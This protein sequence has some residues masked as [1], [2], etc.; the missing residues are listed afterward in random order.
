MSTYYVATTGSNSNNGSI[1]SPFL[2]I[3]KGVSV[4][5]A[6]DTLYIRGGTYL[7]S[8]NSNNQTIPTGTSWTDAPLI[9]AYPSGSGYETV[10]LRPTQWGPV[11]LP[12]DYIKYV[13]FQGMILDG[14]NAPTSTSSSTDGISTGDNLHHVRFKDIEIVN[15]PWNGIQGGGNFME[16][17]NLNVHYSGWFSNSFGYPGSNG[18]YLTTSNSVVDGGRYWNNHAYGMR[19][20]NSGCTNCSINNIVRNIRAYQ[21]GKGIG[22]NGASATTNRGGGIVLGDH[23]NMACNNLIYG[24]FAGIFDY[25]GVGNKYYNNTIYGQAGGY[26][27]ELSNSSGAKVRNNI[28][29]NNQFN[30]IQKNGATLT[31]ESN[32]LFTNPNF[33]N[34]AG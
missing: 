29:Y 16:F 13:I 5:V 33:V 23:N 27:V 3:F 2:T 25:N 7:E 28:I 17:L 22:L 24:N 32:N 9:S 30:V 10:T 34:P 8:I 21:N 1:G 26:A 18:A 20:F 31:E 14:I 6:G 4:L 12:H 11:N 15:A 19:F